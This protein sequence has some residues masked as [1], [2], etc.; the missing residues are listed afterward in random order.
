MQRRPAPRE[1][2]VINRQMITP[3]ML[4]LTLG[5]DGMA[6]FPADQAGGYVKLMLPLPGSE[7]PAVRTYTIRAQR[8]REIDIDFVL[9]EDGGPASRWALDAEPGGKIMVG[10]PGPKKPIDP[11]AGWVLTVGDMTAL[12]AISVNLASLPPHVRGHAVLEILSA[13]DRQDLKKPDGVELHWLVNPLPGQNS[14]LLLD[15]VKTL[16]WPEK[17]PHI[18]TACEFS[19]MKALRSYYLDECSHDKKC[20]YVSSYW[21]HGS[22]EDK[23]KV[24]KREDAERVK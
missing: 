4:R 17:A 14:E 22:S 15:K 9:H 7:R 20:L 2:T 8:Q 24:L 21:K 13:D 18:W 12:P 3:N 19:G 23:H 10:G 1:L 5:G 6:S 16:D 11:T